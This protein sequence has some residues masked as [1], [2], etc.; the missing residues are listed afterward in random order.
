[1]EVPPP[2]DGRRTAEIRSLFD[3]D[4]VHIIIVF[5]PAD[6]PRIIRV[7]LDK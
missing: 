4:D 3:N 2:F 1:M 5:F 6:A 7:V